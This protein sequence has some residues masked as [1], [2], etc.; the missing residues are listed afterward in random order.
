VVSDIR[1]EV[2]NLHGGAQEIAAGNLDMSNRTESQAHNLERTAGSMDT[3]NQTV[4]ETTRLAAEGAVLAENTA[5]VARRSQ[6]AVQT[7]GH[8]MASIAESSRRIGDIIQVIEGVAFQTNIL[9]LNAAV[10]AARAGES[11]RGF[12]V[13][14]SEV[15]ALAQRTTGAAR[16]IRQLIEESRQRVDEGN[17]RTTDAQARMDEAMAAVDKVTAVLENI[18]QATSDQQ[19]GIGEIS[20]AVSHLE[21]ITQQNAAMVEE[22]AA[23]SQTLTSQVNQVHSTMQVFRLTSTDTTLAEI[24]AVALRKAHHTPD[25]RS[26]TV[27]QASQP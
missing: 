18:R 3:I 10:E 20:E 1:T 25:D 14:A 6:E 12:A 16:E 22:L 7:V 9:A 8:S 23:S 24:D 26:S 27:N 19:S 13:V 5:H 2:G 15:R 17:Q 21:R 11:G 4:A